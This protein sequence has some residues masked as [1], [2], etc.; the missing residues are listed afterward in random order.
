MESSL[1]KV[2]K[3]Q[4]KQIE[5]KRGT[6]T[7]LSLGPNYWKNENPCFY[8][9]NVGCNWKIDK[10][11]IGYGV[12]GALLAAYNNHADVVLSP[13]DVWL[14]ICHA[15]SLYLNKNSEILRKEF[16]S[17]EGVKELTI[18]MGESPKISNEWDM[19]IKLFEERICENIK[20]ENRDFLSC[21]F[22]T[23]GAIEKVISGISLMTTFQKYFSYKCITLCGIRNV[24]FLG[25]LED[26]KL[27]LTKADKLKKYGLEKWIE[28]LNVVL[29]QFIETFKGNVDVKFWNNIAIIGGLSGFSCEVLTGWV[30][31][32]FPFNKEGESTADRFS[33]RNNM[34]PLDVL[35]EPI[36]SVPF[37]LEVQ[38][39]TFKYRLKAGFTG[40]LF[41]NEAF[42]PQLSYAIFEEKADN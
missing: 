40:I 33:K 11:E 20:G 39:Q 7:D 10:E 32:F 6:L 22:T 19:M 16:V 38:G 24:I 26:W 41:E 15:F 34:I 18:V 23:T 29:T 1:R 4:E 5:L 21:N 13:D 3:I 28:N 12:A 31:S 35:P 36:F 2:V 30:T 37:I 9:S 14:T 8:K 25:K 27:L 42:R 17:H